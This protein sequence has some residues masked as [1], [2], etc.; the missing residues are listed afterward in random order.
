MEIC[1]KTINRTMMMMKCLVTKIICKRTN[2]NRKTKEKIRISRNN[3][4]KKTV[5]NKKR[6]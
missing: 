4:L 5:T 6:I 3:N 1:K 2:S